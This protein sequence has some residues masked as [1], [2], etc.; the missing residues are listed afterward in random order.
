MKTVK[1]LFF[2]L[3]VISTIAIFSCKKEDTRPDCE[4]NNWGSLEVDSW[5]DDPYSVY[6]DNAYKGTVAGWG[7]VTYNNISSGTHATKYIQNSGYILT[8]T[9]YTL[10]VTITQC[11]TS[12]AKLQ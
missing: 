6:I 2:G 12:T 11:Q 5:L 7:N 4:K 1:L 8:P 3:V 10:S 9:T